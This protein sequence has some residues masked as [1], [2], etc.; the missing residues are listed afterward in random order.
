MGRS[1][2]VAV[3]LVDKVGIAVRDMMLAGAIVPAASVT[4]WALEHWI[5]LRPIT[6]ALLAARL[7]VREGSQRRRWTE[8]VIQIL[9]PHAAASQDAGSQLEPL[10]HFCQLVRSRQVLGIPL[11]ERGVSAPQPA[12]GVARSWAHRLGNLGSISSA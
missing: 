9:W 8:T 2:W 3:L 7:R 5:D 6:A 12:Q 4:V 1:Q 11:G 10:A